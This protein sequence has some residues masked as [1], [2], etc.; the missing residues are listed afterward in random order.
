[1]PDI[2]ITLPDGSTVQIP[3][4]T[5]AEEVLKQKKLLGVKIDGIP[6]D[7]YTPLDRDCR[8]EPITA[9]DPEALHLLRHSAA[10]LMAQAVACVFKDVEFAIGPTIEDGF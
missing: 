4:G 3:L 1:M 8:L 7:S 2:R 5:P 10:H 6:K 9:A